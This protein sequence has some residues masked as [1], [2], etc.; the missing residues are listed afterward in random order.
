MKNQVVRLKLLAIL[1][2]TFS[3]LSACGFHLRG[4]NEFIL[5]FEVLY[6][7]SANNY[8]PFIAE[9]KRTV[10]ATG[11]Q[12]A[13]SPDAAQLTLDVVSETTGKQILSLSGAGRVREYQLRY[14]VSFRAFDKQQQDWLAPDEIVLQRN[15]SYDDEY[16]LAKEQEEV[17]L[18]QNM[19]SDAVQQI[20]RRLTRVRPP[21][22]Q[23]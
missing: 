9:L 7:K 15:L 22:S 11:T 1:L 18:Y 21:R 8:T 16:V 17:L 13:E 10:I 23:Q 2:L 4:Q 3:Q 19:R 6:I 5:P 12:L 20:M 14:V